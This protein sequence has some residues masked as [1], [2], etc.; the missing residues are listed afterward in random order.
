MKHLKLV[1]ALAL[2]TVWVVALGFAG[3]GAHK[4][5]VTSIAH[6]IFQPGRVT[7]NQVGSEAARTSSKTRINIATAAVA[8][9]SKVN[10]TQL[11]AQLQGVTSFPS[12]LHVPSGFYSTLGIAIAVL[13]LNGPPTG[14]TEI[15]LDNASYTEDALVVD[16]TGWGLGQNGQPI[17][18]HPATGVYTT[19][20]FRTTATSGKGFAFQGGVQNVTIDGTAGGGLGL[21]L[22]YATGYTFPSGDALAATIYAEGG[23]NGV[24]VNHATINGNID[25]PYATQTDGRPAIFLFRRAGDATQNQ[26]FTFDHDTVINAT[27]GLKVLAEDGSGDNYTQG[28]VTFTNN[29][30]GGA[31]GGNV[32]LGAF[33]EFCQ[34]INYSNN[35]FDGI[36]YNNAYW[37]NGPTEW[38]ID[39]IFAGAPRSF[40][41]NFGQYSAGHIYYS[42]GASVIHD[43]YVKD[44]HAIGNNGD[45]GILIYG[46]V[47]RLS[48]SGNPLAYNNR[49]TG[50]YNE[51]L[52]G[53]LNGIRAGSLYAYNNTVR[54]VHNVAGDQNMVSQCWN[55]DNKPVNNIFSNEL[56]PA[57]ASFARCEAGVT[58]NSDHNA[59]YAP[60]GRYYATSA[61]LN[62]FLSNGTDANSVF[63]NPNLDANLLI[64]SPSSAE[65]IGLGGL[66]AK[67]ING[68]TRDTTHPDAGAYELVATGSPLGVDILPTV[69]SAPLAGGVPSGLPVAPVVSIKN[70]SNQPVSGATV[71]V[72]ITD[73]YTSGALSI[74][75]IPSNGSVKVTAPNW[76]PSGTSWTI[77]ATVAV[78]GDVNP[79]N[80]VISRAQTVQPPVAIPTGP[81]TVYN[82]DA[83]DQGWTRTVDFQRSNSF[84]KLGGPLSGFSM[85]TI[86]P[87]NP[88]TYTEGA[89]AS[90]EGYAANYPGANML[91]SPWFNLTALST[92]VYVSFSHS[93]A[94]EPGWD[95]AWMEYTNDGIN[96]HKL[97][98]LNDPHGI[99]WYSQ[100]VYQNAQSYTA[101]NN[102]SLPPDTSTM[103]T[104][105][106]LAPQGAISYPADAGFPWWS[107]NGYPGLPAQPAETGQPLGPF[108]YVFAQLHIT[109]A[110][111]PN[112]VGQPLVKF[113]YIAFS[114]AA[115][116]GQG[117][118][119]TSAAIGQAG[120]AVDNFQI[121][122]NGASFS[123]DT[124]QGTVYTDAN[125]NGVN[126]TE[127]PEVG[128][129]VYLSYFGVLK[130]STV[131]DVNGFYQFKTALDNSGLPGTYN[132][133]VVKYG[134]AF[135]QP[136]NTNIANLSGPGTSSLITQ[137]FGTY[138]GSFSDPV[139]NDSLNNGIL[140]SNRGL[141]GWTVEIHADS[142]NGA[143]VASAVTKAGGLDTIPLAPY[144]NYWAKVVQKAGTRGTQNK[145]GASFA[146]SGNSGSPTAILAPINFGE[147]FFGQIRNEASIDYNGDGVKNLSDH[148]P[149]GSGVKQLFEFR[150]EGVLISTD[151]LGNTITSVNHTSLDTGVYTIKRLSA[152]P[153][154]Y[155]KTSAADSF[156]FTITNGNTID[157]A[158][159]LY[160]DYVFAQ[161]N[162]FND[163][164]GNGVQDTL[165]STVRNWPIVVTGTGGGTVLTDSNG[166]WRINTIGPG[167]HTI[168]VGAAPLPGTWTTTLNSGST[169]TANSGGLEYVANNK[170]NV[171]FGEFKDVSIY[172]VKYNDRNDNGAKGAGEEGLAGWVINAAN[173]GGS[174][175]HTDTTDANGNFT[176]LV[177]P[178]P[179]T[180]VVSEVNK[181][182][183]V[184]TQ[185]GGLGKYTIIL[186][187]G[188]SVGYNFGNFFGSDTVKYR[189]WTAAQWF[190]A[191]STK[192]VKAWAVK[193]PTVPN[194]SNVVNNV[195]L[196]VGGPASLQVGAAGQL[197]SASKE[198]AYIL[199]AK[200]SDIWATFSA[201]GTPHDAVGGPPRG[202]DFF[203][204]A[205][206]MLKKQKSV[207][208]SKKDDILIADALALKLNLEISQSSM[209]TLQG[210]FLGN[211]IYKEAGNALGNGTLTVA[212]IST[213]L[214]T[215]MTNWEG[216]P[217]STYVMYDSVIAKINA[218]FSDGSESLPYD[219]SSVAGK[220]WKAGALTMPGLH[221]IATVPYLIGNPGAKPTQAVGGLKPMLPT[222][223]ALAQNYPN[224]FNPTSTVQFD[225]PGASIVTIKV[226]NILGQEVA[227]LLNQQSYSGATR[228]VVTFDGSNLASGVYFY[229]MT[230]QTLDD[231]GQVSGA[232]FTQVKKMMMV[233]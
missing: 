150:K 144:G 157:T 63:G 188:D 80:D 206:V 169:F 221:S 121:G 44:V 127:A 130:D 110:Q 11:P 116:T 86:C 98:V 194:L 184:N 74:P 76:T 148:T 204:N 233:K 210:T 174:I 171:N 39:W 91:I 78:A 29:R 122:G 14:G 141:S 167:S 185:P 109:A 33:T 131:T 20:S 69:I 137:N 136:F 104:Y 147:F 212:T 12:V 207:P 118:T 224:P 30:V 2:L 102:S 96:W 203:K 61:S 36:E 94:T 103:R 113:R 49:I 146:V 158:N 199:G 32:L 75:T 82:W 99:N 9:H 8:S 229:R 149:L 176:F 89:F 168:S 209:L 132:V 145:N 193:K 154:G 28:P 228:D 217:F 21:K 97:G 4:T 46:F 225:V 41:F 111:Y 126:N 58:A 73:G 139:Y 208:E 133:K 138:N 31:F 124:I 1:V 165:E 152:V 218:A 115:N 142:V 47:L 67:D 125:G 129:K 108:G 26:N 23:C 43:N 175:L 232:T 134:W 156:T 100:S 183:W 37:Y 123:G 51:D 190:G 84:T 101:P 114:D 223:Y 192:P 140:G 65:N 227:T 38:D 13:D 40:L 215:L 77:S 66:V 92:D 213:N 59:M 15:I 35:V 19:I 34:G 195:Y 54:F 155:L 7:G 83:S 219:T 93:I 200:Y 201:K 120:W 177:G 25:G 105:G 117:V 17:S 160:F 197:N 161:G 107:S 72:A 205:S 56:Q 16:A 70:N 60:N 211:L 45:G 57:T 3:T 88:A 6:P 27:F 231:N 159:T 230:A 164:N 181:T 162:V 226:Y 64:S 182:G 62:T 214:D 85:V 151:T 10:K 179:D 68:T 191:A 5:A 166:N 95:G 220:G 163:L 178:T 173:T 198:K 112:I 42:D 216:V 106:L 202:F 186:H 81:N 50:L 189:T 79:G 22:N 153:A 90:T 48:L 128:L 135:T 222:V 172:G 187:S 55:G 87:A 52:A 196:L 71:T 170:Y 18:I 24:T 53:Q 143:L 119:A 180:L